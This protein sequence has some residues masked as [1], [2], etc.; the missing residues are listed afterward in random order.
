[1]VAAAVVVA[2]V[3]AVVVAVVVAAEA[4]VVAVVEEATLVSLWPFGTTATVKEMSISRSMDSC[5]AHP[6]AGAPSA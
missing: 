3:A 2:V 6:A 1:M 4:G 5:H